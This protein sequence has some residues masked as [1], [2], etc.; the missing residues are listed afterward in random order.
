MYRIFLRPPRI[1]FRCPLSEVLLPEEKD[2]CDA[3]VGDGREDCDHCPLS[4]P[5]HAC[6]SEWC[7][8][9]A[10]IEPQAHQKQSGMRR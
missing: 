2:A 4:S 3:D 1:G 9:D 6:R 10:G 8:P 7:P 5:W